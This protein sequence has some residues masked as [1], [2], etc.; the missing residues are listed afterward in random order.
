MTATLYPGWTFPLHINEDIA[1]NLWEMAEA[2][3]RSDYPPTQ[4]AA[5][6]LSWDDAFKIAAELHAAQ[7]IAHSNEMVQVELRR[8]AEAL[9]RL[10][11]T[12]N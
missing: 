12:Q 4:H 8:I 9:D 11:D 1:T 7:K 10:A 5:A 3:R 6:R 2:L